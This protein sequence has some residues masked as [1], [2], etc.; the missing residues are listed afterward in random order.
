M[1]DNKSIAWL[2]LDAHSK[3]CVLA[4]L[5]ESGVQ[6]QWWRFATSVEPLVQH[7]ARV[8]APDKRLVLEESNPA[9][10]ISQTLRPHVQQRVVCDARHNRLI[11]SHPNKHDQRDAFGL[12]RL[13]RL[14][15]IKPVWQPQEDGRGVIRSG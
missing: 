15:E 9:R 1:N 13:F 12:A 3:N 7:L 4:H 14:G 5:D 6:R 8:E 2:G 10:W 11:S